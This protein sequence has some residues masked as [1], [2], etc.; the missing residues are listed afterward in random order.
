[1]ANIAANSAV[2]SAQSVS[3]ITHIGIFEVE[4]THVAI[5]VS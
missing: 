1:V 2:M 3:G 5:K 4:K